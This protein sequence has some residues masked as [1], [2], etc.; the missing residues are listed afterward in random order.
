[1]ALWAKEYDLKV[2]LKEWYFPPSRLLRYWAMYYDCATEKLYVHNQDSFLRCNRNQEE[3]IFYSEQDSEWMPTDSVVPLQVVT[4][5][6]AK[7]WTD[8]Y[9]YGLKG[10][11]PYHLD[12][13]LHSFVLALDKWEASLLDSNR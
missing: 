10:S 1:M 13:M 2:S 9:C 8:N 4:S 6:S 7:T 3:G 5:D 11:I 12:G